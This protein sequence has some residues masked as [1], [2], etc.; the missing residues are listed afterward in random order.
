MQPPT[1]MTTTQ[2]GAGKRLLLLLLRGK[3]VQPGI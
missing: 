2:V 1:R 3:A